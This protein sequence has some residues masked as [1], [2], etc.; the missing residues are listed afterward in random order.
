M[1]RIGKIVCIGIRF[2]WT[3]VRAP[4]KV[5]VISVPQLSRVA[6]FCLVTL[7]SAPFEGLFQLLHSKAFTLELYTNWRDVFSILGNA[8]FL[9]TRI[10]KSKRS[11]MA[12]NTEY[13]L[14]FTH[15]NGGYV[16]L[17]V[18]VYKVRSNQGLY[19]NNSS[20]CKRATI[21]SPWI[22]LCAHIELGTAGRFAPRLLLLFKTVAP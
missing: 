13:L 14:V 19:T 17:F 20:S 5:P 4:I 1:C 12:K 10:V 11:S 16:R 2:D 7:G 3:S 18:L 21:Q 22:L 8:L 6:P 15:T 9:V